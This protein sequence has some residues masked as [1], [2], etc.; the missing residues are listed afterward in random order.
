MSR[1]D[2]L[3]TTSVATAGLLA[4]SATARAKSKRTNGADP[5]RYCLNMSTI[6]GQNLSVTEEIDVAAK[7][8]YSGIEPWL[9]KLND[10]KKNGGSL[11]DLRK[12][13][14]D[15]GLTVES[16]IGFAR[17]IVDDDTQRAK[18]LEEA[19]RDMDLLAQLGAKRIAAPP[20]GARGVVDPMAAAERYR[21]LLESG[22]EIGVVPQIE[23]WGGNPSIGRVSTAIYIALEAGHPS[24]CFLGDV[25]HTYKGGSDFDALKMLGPQAL[26][27]FHWNDYPAVPPLDK[28]GDGDRVFPGDGIAPIIDI[29]NGFLQVGAAPA[30]SLELFNKN[31]WAMDALE[32]A[33]VGIEKMKA[34]VAPAL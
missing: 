32:A 5:F 18:G 25:Y 12:R 13:I 21:A 31:Y 11:K 24:A 14:D 16:A 29:V 28:I 30:L 4:G 3:K 2:L 1:R 26:Q 17:W 34:S 27:V 23:M 8:G 10:Y 15:H 33:K 6:R 19:R 20:A 22:D 9:G 7:A